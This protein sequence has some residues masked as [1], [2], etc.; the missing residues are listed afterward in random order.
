MAYTGH[1]YGP[2]CSLQVDSNVFMRRASVVSDDPPK[3]RA[4][5]FYNSA[6]PIDDPLSPVPLPSTSSIGPSK[7]PPR[8][9]S[10][11][12]NTALEETWQSLQVLDNAEKRLETAHNSRNNPLT[13][14]NLTNIIRSVS[15]N[16]RKEKQRKSDFSEADQADQPKSV[17]SPAAESTEHADSEATEKPHHD[18]PQ[19]IGDPHL[20]LCD[21][22][23]HIPFDET[24][25]VGPGEIDN[26]EFESAP[27]K[28][29][30][31]SPFRRKDKAERQKD[32]N[33]ASPRRRLS[34]NKRQFAEEQYGSSPLERDTTGTPFLRV[35]NR[36]SKSRSRSSDREVSPTLSDDAV[37]FSESDVKKSSRPALTRDNSSVPSSSKG[38][39]PEEPLKSHQSPR[40]KEKQQRQS[41]VTV[42][43]SRLHLVK[44]P[45]LKVNMVDILC[46]SFL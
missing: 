24:M 32:K 5:F 45:S 8:P 16:K 44:M 46:H 40:R 13:V 38:L 34:T 6:L 42:G 19:Q 41:S 27:P 26:D 7:F 25:P 28:R 3:T 23:S 29:R 9:F 20:M 35:P 1:N 12:D 4:H 11:F 31:Q 21:D 39:E 2:S 18:Q 43:V 14:E 15:P 37:S 30:H 33:D 36:K 10:V 17:T 22:P